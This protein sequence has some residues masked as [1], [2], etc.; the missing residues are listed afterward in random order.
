MVRQGDSLW[1]GRGVPGVRPTMSHC[2]KYNGIVARRLPDREGVRGFRRPMVEEYH[3]DP[4]GLASIIRHNPRSQVR[5]EFHGRTDLVR[6]RG[7]RGGL[8]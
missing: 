2:A 7:P 4:Y 5:P 1:R 6:G 3:R 8:G